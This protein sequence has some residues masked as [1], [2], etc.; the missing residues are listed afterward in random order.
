MKMSLVALTSASCLAAAATWLAQLIG[1]KEPSVWEQPAI[2]AAV[3]SAGVGLTVLALTQWVLHCREKTSLLLEKL[4]ILYTNLSRLLQLGTKRAEYF[5]GEESIE[6]LMK[7][8]GTRLTNE[9]IM[10]QSFH[11]PAL[12]QPITAV[13]RENGKVTELLGGPN[14][15]A[16]SEVLQAATIELN[17]LIAIVSTLICKEQAKLTQAKWYHY[18][19]LLCRL[20]RPLTIP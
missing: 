19:P 11:F 12:Q 7:V 17:R 9:I 4:E 5:S 8:R 15:A 1:P 10:L 6:G 18:I 14:A 3:I 20:C 2:L 16:T 13:L